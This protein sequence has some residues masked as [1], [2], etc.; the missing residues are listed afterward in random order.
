MSFVGTP[1]DSIIG[2][3]G[4]EKVSRLDDSQWDNEAHIRPGPN[5]Y[6]ISTP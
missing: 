4:S 3:V 1:D 6:S 2:K 5:L